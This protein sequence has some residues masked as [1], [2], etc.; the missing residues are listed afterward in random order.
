MKLIKNISI[1][2]KLITII[3][4]VTLLSLAIGLIITGYLDFLELKEELKHSTILNAQMTG[5]YCAS[6]L[7]FEEQ[8]G[9]KQILSKLNN[10]PEI[11]FGR[12]YDNRGKIFADFG[13]LENEAL[14]KDIQEIEAKTEFS[15]SYLHV[16]Q[17]VH[18]DEKKYGTIYLLASTELLDK[19]VREHFFITFIVLIATIFIASFLAVR[20]QRFISQPILT[21]ADLTEGISRDADFSVRIEKKGSDE[22]GTLYDS[23]NNMLEQIQIREKE[24]LKKDFIIRSASTIIATANL[25]GMMTYVNPVFLETW[26]FDNTDEIIGRTFPEFWMVSDRMDEIMT[27]L[28]G[29]EKKWS[30]EIHAKKKDGSLFDVLVSAAT[31]LDDIGNPIALMSTSIDI[32]ERKHAETEKTRL[33]EQYHQAQ[34]VESIG[35]LAGGVAHDLNNLLSPIIGY[36]EVLLDDFDS[37]DRRRESVDEILRAGIRARD[38]VRQLLAF[39]RK[40]NLEYK[41]VN[42]NQALSN[43]VTL[44]R[45]TIREDIEIEIIPSRDKGIIMADIGQIEQV[46]M[47][48]AVNAQDAMPDGGKLTIETEPVILDE[49]YAA[50]HQE[51]KPGSYLML[52]VSDTGVGIDEEILEQVFEP[53]FSTKGEQGTGLGLATV[54]GIVK[55]HDGSIWVYSELGKG[56]TFKIYLP[57]SKDK[58]VDK[59]HGKKTITDLEGTEAILLVED[60]EQVR[61]LAHTILKRKGY[62]VLVAENGPEA[63]DILESNDEHVHLLLTDVIMPEMNG[64]ELFDKISEKYTDLKVLYMSGYTDNVIAHHGVLEDG[65]N[66]IQKPFSVQA[67]ASKVREALEKE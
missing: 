44:L 36:G 65:I 54:Y 5:D 66:F 43:F 58:V 3:L 62:N 40:Q 27:A 48:L 35:R 24:L 45:R 37:Q 39:S 34:K 46:I 29:E 10:I 28:M 1:R 63:L 56:T 25:D 51:A 23:F 9:A 18:Y 26:G 32:T 4:T 6:A 64:K 53:F 49:E 67:L 50:I 30:G 31:V 21:L 8:Q 11:K 47:N 55:Q 42:L 19:R 52:A 16:I 57:V 14:L 2:S 15:E 12:L 13:K 61:N 59:I 20:M 22:I 7:V 60:N 17:P 33:E 41:P 38:L